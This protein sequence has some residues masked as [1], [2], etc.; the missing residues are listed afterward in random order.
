MKKQYIL[1]FLLLVG[2]GAVS[3]MAFS[4]G[5]ST[6]TVAAPVT[7]T[8]DGTENITDVKVLPYK[9]DDGVYLKITVNTADSMTFYVQFIDD[10]SGDAIDMSA[11]DTTQ[12]K[13]GSAWDESVTW[14]ADYE[15]L[16]ITATGTDFTSVKVRVYEPDSDVYTTIEQVV[17]IETAHSN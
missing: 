17:L 8:G 15:A 13:V 12:C 2:L 11:Y 6:S 4:L 9:G 16:E 7:I 10:D 14:D 3:T 1:A 5:E